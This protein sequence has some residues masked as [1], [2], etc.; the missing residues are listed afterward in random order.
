MAQR[1]SSASAPAGLHVGIIMDGNGRWA[2][3]QGLPRGTGHQAGADAVRRIVETASEVGVGILSLFAFSS[4]NWRRPAVEVTWLMRLFREYIR[5]E[6]ARCIA[7]G[8]RL[9]VIGRRDRAR[10]SPAPGLE[11]AGGGA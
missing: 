4:D 10:G 6:T 7:N 5:T 1:P 9:E 8:V 11:A 2:V 3:Q